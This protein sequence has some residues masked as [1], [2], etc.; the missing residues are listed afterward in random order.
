MAEAADGVLVVRAGEGEA[1]AV[2]GARILR[3]LSAEDAGGHFS[4]IEY[5]V[6]PRFAAPAALHWHTK[7]SFTAYVLEGRI[8]FRFRDRTEALGPGDVLKAPPGCPFAW[9][10]P[11]DEPARILYIY[12]PGGFDAYFAEAA[13]VIAANPQTPI[14]D[15]APKLARLWTKYGI[16]SEA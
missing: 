11:T 7:E 2:G 8:E 14:R 4:L 12:A 5:A 13:G 6:G 1:I 15:L 16:Q 9:L 3:K 10:N